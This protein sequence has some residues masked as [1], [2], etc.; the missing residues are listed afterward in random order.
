MRIDP[1]D[2]YTISLCMWNWGMSRARVLEEEWTEE[3]LERAQKY[4]E[5]KHIDPVEEVRL[6]T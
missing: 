2:I 4:V 6:W 3:E 1:N 5:L